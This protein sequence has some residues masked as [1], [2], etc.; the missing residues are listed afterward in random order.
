LIRHDSDS[1]NV[2]SLFALDVVLYLS[3]AL[4]MRSPGGLL[5]AGFWLL[6]AIVG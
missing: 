1:T 5:V 3:F 2:L 4:S 6:W